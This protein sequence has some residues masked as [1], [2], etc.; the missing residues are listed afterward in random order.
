MRVV[1]LVLDLAVFAGFGERDTEP[2][3]HY[4]ILTTGVARA[5][6]VCG[7]IRRGSR[8]PGIPQSLRRVGKAHL[9][10]GNT[11]A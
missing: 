3:P 7:P 4:T 2:V 11:F 5:S 1:I 9:S 10:K 6:Q 8:S